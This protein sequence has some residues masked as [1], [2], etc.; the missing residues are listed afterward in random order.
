[1]KKLWCSI[2][3]AFLNAFDDAVDHIAYAIDTL[4]PPVL[5]LLSGVGEVAGGVIK[6]VGSA[7]SGVFNGSPLLWGGLLV[8]GYFLLTGSSDKEDIKSDQDTSKARLLM[9]NDF[10][11]YQNSTLRTT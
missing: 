1:M 11:S 9:D 10:D 2:W 8:A 5:N 7:I 6:D 4:T 3:R